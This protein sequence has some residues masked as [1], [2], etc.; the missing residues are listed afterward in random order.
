MKELSKSY[1]PDKH[2]SSIYQKWEESGFFNPDN[3]P[4]K[5]KKV[6]SVSLPPPNATGILH[7]GHASML[8]YQDIMVRYHRLKGDKTL[9]LPGTD[10]A[11][12]A[13]Q[14][15]VEKKLIKEEKKRKEDIGREEFRKR[16]DK[17]VEE[18]RGTIRKQLR[19]MGSSLDWSR[20]R[21]TLDKDLSL[22]VRTAFAKM[23]NDGLI[24]RGYRIVNWC[25]HCKSTLA[26]DE[27]E[28]KEQKAPFYY[29]KY[30]PVVIG[31]AR[32]E[33]KF[34]DKVII[35]HPKDKRF[36]DI[37]GKEFEVEW[38]NGK[39]KAKVITDEAAD[40]EMGTG[41]MTITPAHSFVDFDLAQ[42]YKLKV[43]EIIDK[44]GN[45]TEVAG[46]FAG[47]PAAK[48]REKIVNKLA[49]KG[50]VD[51]IDE[52][53]VHNL[54][55]CYRCKTPIE[56]LPSKQWFVDVNKKIPK[57]GKSLKQLASD[58]VKNGDIKII[59]DKF[60]KTYFQWMDN[61]RDWCISRQ[62]WYGHQIPVWYRDAK[63]QKRKSA[64][65]EQDIIVPKEITEINLMRHGL[66]DWNKD[67]KIQ[68]RTNVP[69]DES[70][71]DKIN[72]IMPQLRSENFDIIISS[73][74]MRAKQTAEIVNKQL[75]LPLIEDELLV[76]R[77]YGKFEGKKVNDIKNDHPDYAKDKINYDIP[78]DDE[79]TYQEI[80]QRLKKFIKQ[81]SK[82]YPNKKILV[83]CH[84]AVIR[85]FKMIIKDSSP[86][87]LSGYKPSFD[88]LVKYQILDGNYNLK[89]VEQDPDTLDTWFSSSLWTFS[90]LGW[91]DKTDDLKAYHPTSVMETGYDIL[92]FWVARMILMSEYLLGQKPFETVY[93]HGLVKDKEGRKM[94]KSLGNG[95]DP[96]AMIDKFG[97]DALRLA[98]IVGASAGNDIRLYEEKI[99]GYRN[100]VNK[101]WNISRY[102]LSTVGQVKPI[103]K[104]PEAKTLADK[105]IL[106]EF[107]QI[108]ESTTGNIEQFKFSQA[109][110]E[111]YEFT[112]S[113]LADWYLEI[114][115][116]EEG[117][118]EILLYIL[119]KLL[120]LWHP[121]C[122]F[123]TEVIWE[124]FKTD[125]LLM[126]KEWPEIKKQDIKNKIQDEFEKVQEIV[127]AIRNTRAEH[128]ANP[129]KVYGCSI[130]TSKKKVIEENKNIIEA[131]AKIKIIPKATG[132]AIN[133]AW[134]DMILDIKENREV[135]KNK[136]KETVNLERYIQIQEAKLRNKDFTKKAPPKVVEE[137][138]EK[139]SQAKEKLAKLK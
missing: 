83:I 110:E 10:H 47:Q 5:R 74:L 28:Y 69:L 14:T 42:K 20:E 118:D 134:A 131:L 18:S 76:E 71:V 119:E 13:T 53:Y 114:A 55:L 82:E 108:V 96:I 27:V 107:N 130:K 24:Y 66:T 126:I 34:S 9:W 85:T 101:L 4:G 37:A 26:D 77:N 68:G 57:K 104:L 89:G 59:P 123:I 81:V 125:K 105:W 137:E 133:L 139:L 49:K 6:F 33:T 109:G 56:P 99:A 44:D 112:W 17:Y 32:P 48:A 95:I 117:K 67:Q 22:A 3:L 12:I 127:S 103:E 93:L 72:K 58:V 61:L 63:A 92:F 51:K 121:F 15:V 35:V 11:A 41:A 62:I 87:E 135:A 43:E 40:M 88:K 39:I 29:F 84:N 23:Y 132:V 64:K 136:A 124:I 73:P 54:S 91:P 102:I 78:G 75:N 116:V 115:K 38:I 8:A 52:D 90:T 80:A 98:M 120:I 46:E 36:K 21:F 65:K 16:I 86:K 106:L 100:F 1:Q 138:K 7:I 97:T 45:L 111:L 2:E 128:L 60:N 129:K 113:K 30:G 50:L 19:A 79:E 122:P 31:T 70:S 94:S 25:P